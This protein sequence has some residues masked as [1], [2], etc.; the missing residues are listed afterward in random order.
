MNGREVAL[1]EL[2]GEARGIVVAA[3]LHCLDVLN[4]LCDRLQHAN[5]A[6]VRVY[7]EIN[8][9]SVVLAL[10]Q[11]LLVLVLTHMLER[12]ALLGPYGDAHPAVV[13]HLLLLL[14][15][16]RAQRSRVVLGQGAVRGRAFSRLRK[17]DFRQWDG[18]PLV[19]ALSLVVGPSRHEAREFV[20][21]VL[22]GAEEVGHNRV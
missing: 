9:K 7:D 1:L 2:E 22:V 14:V 6:H 20:V 12:V 11:R 13:E 5:R 15:A 10:E 17:V 16:F 3:L 19:G 18:E 21:Q 8:L 4:L